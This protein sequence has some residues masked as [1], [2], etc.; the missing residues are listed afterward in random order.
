MHSILHTQNLRPVSC[1]LQLVWNNFL[2]NLL[3]HLAIEK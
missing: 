1:D 2:A 3:L